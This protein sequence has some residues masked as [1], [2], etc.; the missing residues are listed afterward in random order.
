MGQGLCTGQ[1]IIKKG[2]KLGQAEWGRCIAERQKHGETSGQEDV[3]TATQLDMSMDN[4]THTSDRH[5]TYVCVRQQ[6][7][8]GPETGA[9][10]WAALGL[11]PCSTDPFSQPFPDSSIPTRRFSPGHFQTASL[12]AEES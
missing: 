10:K 5:T 4:K 12:W 8:G 2:Q 3:M 7:E 11:T 9:C 1:G 6:N